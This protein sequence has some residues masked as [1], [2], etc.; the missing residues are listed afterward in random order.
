[1]SGTNNG[2]SGGVLTNPP[3]NY[4]DGGQKGAL[5]LLQYKALMSHQKLGHV[6]EPVFD[7]TLPAKESTPLVA[8]TND[9]AM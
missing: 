3:A 5:W 6:L 9:T 7:A 1:M 4:G 8:G 2:Y